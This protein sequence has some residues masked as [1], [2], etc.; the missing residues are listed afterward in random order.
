MLVLRIYC[1]GIF[2]INAWDCK[3]LDIRHR[4]VSGWALG[5]Q[6][7][8]TKS[9]TTRGHP[10]PVSTMGTDLRMSLL[11]ES[12]TRGSRG[13]MLRRPTQLSRFPRRGDKARVATEGINDSRTLVALTS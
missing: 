7:M 11:P 13:R 1:E 6:C 3:Q 8:T 5:H 10:A 2:D 4:L 9:M 12:I